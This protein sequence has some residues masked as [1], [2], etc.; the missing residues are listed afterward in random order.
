MH[1]YATR[2]VWEGNLGE[3]T[4]RYT[5]YGRAYRV[6]IAGKADLAGSADPAFRGQA[7]RHNP[8][9]LFLA[10]VSACHMLSYLALC[11]RRGLRVVGYQDAAEARLDLDAGRLADITLRPEV[12]L[13]PGGDAAVAAELH[14][15]AH[16]RCFIARSCAVPIRVLP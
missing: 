5:G 14:D 8:E 1:R 6:V 10:A 4:A 15:A 9:E 3:G 11:A 16:A 2:T 7:D 12:I 13:A